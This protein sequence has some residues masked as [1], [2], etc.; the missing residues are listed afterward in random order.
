MNPIRSRTAAVLSAFV[1]LSACALFFGPV[2]STVA[3]DFARR[4]PSRIAVL[5]VANETL[6]TEGP[7]MIRAQVEKLL[8]S[9]GYQL[10]P[11]ARVDEILQ[12]KLDIVYG[13]QT[14]S[15]EPAQLAELL[16]ADGLVYTKLI[17]WSRTR[18]VERDQLA[19]GAEFELKSAASKD[20]L[21]RARHE[22]YRRAEPRSM[23]DPPERRE[24]TQ[25]FLALVK[26]LVRDVGATLPERPR[27][28]AAR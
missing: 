7:P 27:E 5:P 20:L 25:E 6:Y 2:E 19:V 1:L 18:I 26:D 9:R 22:V 8:E 12:D 11:A 13:G 28:P 14:D 24:D 23:F 17:E 3:P 15:V 4:C 21:W 10:V 16:G